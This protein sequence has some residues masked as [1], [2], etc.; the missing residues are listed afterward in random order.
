MGERSMSMF[1]RFV[2]D[3]SGATAIEY[4][5]IA[6][7]VSVAIIVMLGT[8]GLRPERYLQDCCRPAD[9]CRGGVSPFGFGGIGGQAGSPMPLTAHTCPAADMEDP[10]RAEVPVNARA[11]NST[12]QTRRQRAVRRL[13][14]DSGA[15]GVEYGLLVALIAL[16]I[17]GT[18]RSLGASLASLPLQSIIDAI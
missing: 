10:R 5:L 2:K 7:L 15:I 14:E 12:Y 8:L 16:A 13:A 9:R 4:G 17:L 1:R 18:V 3:D 11:H 6:A